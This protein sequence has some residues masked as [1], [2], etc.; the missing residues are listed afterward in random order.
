[1]SSQFN[2]YCLTIMFVMMPMSH[3][4]AQTEDLVTEA[5]DGLRRSLQSIK[6]IRAK[7]VSRQTVPVVTQEQGDY[8]RVGETE[9]VHQE[10]SDGSRHDRLVRSGVV[11]SLISVAKPSKNNASQA[12]IETIQDGYARCSAYSELL[13]HH[14]DSSG[15]VCSYDDLLATSQEPITSERTTYRGRSCIKITVASTDPAK[16]RVETAFWHD[17]QAGYWIIKTELR[18][19]SKKMMDASVDKI[20]SAKTDVTMPVHATYQF[21]TEKGDVYQSREFELQNIA[22]NERIS[23]A[24]LSLPSPPPG[25]YL[26]DRI[27][28]VRGVMDRSWSIAGQSEPSVRIMLPPQ[29]EATNALTVGT[30]TQRE[31]LSFGNG[32]L[33]FSL[34]GGIG[35]VLIWLLRRYRGLSVAPTSSGGNHG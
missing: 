3:A 18:S 21:Y 15:R 32:L 35:L 16:N 34:A 9:R 7:F 27:K 22:V 19:Q 11:K 20:E 14:T 2:W 10:A 4:S 33:F 31:P 12:S 1:M 5:K 23:E 25:T 13:I 29:S 26:N 28:G 30:A 6:T 8:L 17:V 24:E